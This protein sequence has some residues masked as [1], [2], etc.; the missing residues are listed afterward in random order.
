MGRHWLPLIDGCSRD[1]QA[2]RSQEDHDA[3]QGV[4]VNDPLSHQPLVLEPDEGTLEVADDHDGQE[5]Q[6]IGR[7]STPHPASTRH[8]ARGAGSAAHVPVQHQRGPTGQQ[9]NKQRCIVIESRGTVKETGYL[10]PFV[11]SSIRRHGNLQLFTDPHRGE[12][13]NLSMPRY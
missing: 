2:V 1:E 9:R 4:E 3:D 11:L 10:V 8:A 5:Q 7:F 6:I 12:V 13:R